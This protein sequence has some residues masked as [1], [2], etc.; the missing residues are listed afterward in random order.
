MQE[1]IQTFEAGYRGVLHALV[2][3]G[4]VLEIVIPVNNC[5]YVIAKGHPHNLLIMY[6]RE[7]FYNFGKIFR[8]KG[9]KGVGDSINVSDLKYAIQ[10]DVKEI[11][12]IFPNGYVYKVNMQ[13]F[14]E[15]SIDWINKEGKEVRSISIHVYE[16]AFEL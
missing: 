11:Y 1:K 15:N 4:Y 3:Q 5:R 13:K 6:K 14:L 12:T 9:F 16:R 7:P 10:S 2:Q 8:N